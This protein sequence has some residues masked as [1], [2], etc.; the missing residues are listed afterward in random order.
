[1]CFIL[2]GCNAFSFSEDDINAK[3]SGARYSREYFSIC[4]NFYKERKSINAQ[5]LAKSQKTIAIF[6]HTKTIGQTTYTSVVKA[7]DVQ[8]L[9]LKGLLKRI[10]LNIPKDHLK[11]FVDEPIKPSEGDLIIEIN[12]QV[13]ITNEMISEAQVMVNTKYF[14]PEL[15]RWDPL[16]NQYWQWSFPVIAAQKA[17]VEKQVTDRMNMDSDW[18]NLIDDAVWLFHIPLKKDILI[19]RLA[20]NKDDVPAARLLSLVDWDSV[21]NTQLKQNNTECL[22]HAYMMYPYSD[23]VVKEVY[24]E[25]R[26]ETP[27]FMEKFRLFVYLYIANYPNITKALNELI[28]DMDSADKFSAAAPLLFIAEDK[29]NEETLEHLRNIRENIDV[30]SIAVDKQFSVILGQ[31]ISSLEKKFGTAQ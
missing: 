4:E 18:K 23:K 25:F 11:I 3:L 13:E 19:G 1:M 14:I 7:H 5:F 16:Y 20:R 9:V 8:D 15:Y 29:G 10:G 17:K 12:T 2:L 24:R 31:A 6:C 30:N 26:T 28:A 27:V 22:V 21:F